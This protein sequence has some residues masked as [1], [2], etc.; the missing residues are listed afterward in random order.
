VLGKNCK[1]RAA[2]TH[3][4]QRFGNYHPS[5]YKMPMGLKDHLLDSRNILKW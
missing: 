3:V 4:S 5:I 2:T 1:I